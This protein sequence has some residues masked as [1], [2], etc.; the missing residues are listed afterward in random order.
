MPEIYYVRACPACK[1]CA[2]LQKMAHATVT[3]P[4]TFDQVNDGTPGGIF[5]DFCCEDLTPAHE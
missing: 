3:G 2:E 4:Y 1:E 5:C